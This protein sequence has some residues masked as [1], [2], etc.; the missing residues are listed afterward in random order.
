MADPRSTAA[1]TGLSASVVSGW[2][3]L[4][5]VATAATARVSSSAY[6]V[7]AATARCALTTRAA[8]IISIALVIFLVALTERMRRL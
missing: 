6:G 2:L 4:E 5:L 1:R 7:E 3:A 8:A